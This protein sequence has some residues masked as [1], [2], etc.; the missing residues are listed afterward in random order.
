[1]QRVGEVDGLRVDITSPTAGLVI[2]LP[3][4]P[5]GQW[6]VFDHVKA[7]QI[8]ARIDD[9]QLEAS[10]SLLRWDIKDLQDKL[11]RSQSADTTL[12]DAETREVIR[13]AWGFERS[14]LQTLEH[15]LSAAPQLTPRELDEMRSPHLELPESVPTTIRYELARVREERC[16]L[17]LRWEELSLRST[18]LEILAPITGTL[19]NIPIAGRDKSSCPAS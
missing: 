12:I 8:I 15:L 5:R 16:V 2:A 1:M 19:T 9:Q 14:R 4:E 18:L 6:T 11:V 7:G 13:R 10:K 3:H 17:D